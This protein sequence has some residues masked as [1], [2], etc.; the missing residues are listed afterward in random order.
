MPS[1]QI[2]V[3]KR[4]YNWYRLNKKLLDPDIVSAMYRTSVLFKFNDKDTIA[5][6]R[7]CLK[8]TCQ[9]GIT[10]FSIVKFKFR[11]Y[12]KAVAHKLLRFASLPKKE[13]ITDVFLQLCEVFQNNY[14]VKDLRMT[15]YCSFFIAKL[16]EILHIVTVAALLNLNMFFLARMCYLHVWYLFVVLKIAFWHFVWTH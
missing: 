9:S 6:L 15:G 2:E 5:M 1:K 13:T 3:L 8:L 7:N 16:D 12:S 11:Y 10:I 4:I 14:S